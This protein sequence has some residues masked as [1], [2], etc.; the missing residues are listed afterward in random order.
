MVHYSVLCDWKTTAMVV[1]TSVPKSDICAI[2][3]FLTLENVLRHE[4][5][6]SLCAT[7]KNLNIVTKSIV[8]FSMRSF[9]EGRM[10]T[11]EKTCSSSPPDI[12]N[13]ETIA[14]MHVL[15]EEDWWQIVHNIE[16]TVHFITIFWFLYAAHKWQWISYPGTF[17]SVRNWMTACVSDL[18]D[19][20]RYHRYG[21]S[22]IQQLNN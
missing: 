2:I 21:F 13:D 15:S 1:P 3:Q 20:C 17:S 7:Y 10:S 12:V 14:I 5:Y 6:C 4:I 16:W 18:G 22:F 11:D 19:W 8:N 9:K